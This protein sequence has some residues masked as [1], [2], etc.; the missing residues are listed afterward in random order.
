MHWLIV[1][2]LF[3]PSARAEEIPFNP[4]VARIFRAALTKTRGMS[5][6]PSSSLAEIA[7]VLTVEQRRLARRDLI[8]FQSTVRSPEEFRVI[9]YAHQLL[10][11]ETASDFAHAASASHQAGEHALAVSFAKEALKRDKNNAMARSALELSRGRRPVQN[12]LRPVSDAAKSAQSPKMAP[13]S[14]LTHSRREPPID[15]PLVAVE[16]PSDE[17]PGKPT[18]LVPLAVGAGISLALYGVARSRATWSQ[19]ETTGHRVVIDSR[20]DA[21]WRRHAR[22]AVLSAGV[23]FGLAYGIPLLLA[24]A[25]RITTA[26]LSTL[27][28]SGAKLVHSNAGSIMPVKKNWT[29]SPRVVEQLRD[30][31]LGVLAGKL[32]ADDLKR[33]ANSPDA[34]RIFDA[35]TN[36]I[37]II[38]EVDG[39][40]LRITVPKDELKII[41]VGPIRPNQLRNRIM[42]GDFIPMP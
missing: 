14:V 9:A 35:R 15:V 1:V 41:S 37:N 25:A 19:Q 23:G 38:Q 22:A 40:L 6:P 16:S 26:S 5:L 33:L 27:G 8:F 36:N 10:A 34:Q 29:V 18:P 7:A 2:T 11:P 28:E 13:A 21:R 39:V 24:P 20:D 3:L 4:E 17:A 42:A 30:V 31:R 12:S 32:N